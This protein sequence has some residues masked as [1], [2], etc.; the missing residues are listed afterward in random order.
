M[1]NS[2]RHK[3]KRLHRARIKEK[4][5]NMQRPKRKPAMLR[6]VGKRKER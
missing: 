5:T 4:E 2:I 1:S 3:E 6:P